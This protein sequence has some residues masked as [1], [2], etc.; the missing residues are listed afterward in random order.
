M[1]RRDN[2]FG[3]FEVD[4]RVVEVV[5]GDDA[6]VGQAIVDVLGGEGIDAVFV[7]SHDQYVGLQYATPH[8]VLLRQADVD[9]ARPIIDA[10]LGESINEPSPRSPVS[11]RVRVFT[12]V[13]LGASVGGGFIVALVQLVT[14]L[15]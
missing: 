9:A 4:D 2:P 12:A 10:Y 6:F 7:E 1:S 8:K 5:V 14:D 15:F 11:R 3:G 13:I